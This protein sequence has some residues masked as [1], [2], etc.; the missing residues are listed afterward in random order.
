MAEITIKPD[1]FDH[2]WALHSIFEFQFYNCPECDF[3]IKEKQEFVCHAYVDHPGSEE[4]LSLISDGSLSD[5]IFPWNDGQSHVIKEEQVDVSD[6]KYHAHFDDNDQ[7]DNLDDYDEEEESDQ[8]IQ[9][10][11]SRRKAPVKETPDSDLSENE[12]FD[13]NTKWTG[14]ENE[15]SDDEDFSVSDTEIIAAEVEEEKKR[16]KGLPKRKDVDP[17]RPKTKRIYLLKIQCNICDSLPK[18]PSVQGLD[19]HMLEK[20]GQELNKFQCG[21]CDASWSTVHV[22][23][24]HHAVDHDDKEHFSCDVCLKVFAKPMYRTQHQRV[25]HDGI[26]KDKSQVCTLC[27]WKGT[28]MKLHWEEHHPDEEPPFK[29]DHCDF[30]GV[31][32]PSLK[33]HKRYNHE[34]VQGGYKS[35]EK[36]FQCDQCPYASKTSHFLKKHIENIHMKIRKFQCDSCPK[37]FYS[38]SSFREHLVRIHRQELETPLITMKVKRRLASKIYVP[39]I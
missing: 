2:P 18:Y 9:R 30:R 3:K 27:E 21:R 35:A 38:E 12:G 31:T 4:Y 28:K 5:V 17:H 34:T 36:N 29:C 10:R 37:S 15:V 19:Q 33:R 25:V 13:T 20:H 22:L 23:D 14:R 1:I 7:D 32:R 26:K 6:I 8:M 24:T 16:P 11:S 39:F